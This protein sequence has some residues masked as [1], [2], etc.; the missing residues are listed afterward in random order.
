MSL[1]FRNLD[2]SAKKKKKSFSS[3]HQASTAPPP[4]MPSIL[5]VDDVESIR[6]MTKRLLVSAGCT[7]I[8]TAV[9]GEDA[10]IKYANSL[11]TSNQ[12]D[13]IFMDYTMPKM[14]G[15]DATRCIRELGFEGLVIGITGNAMDADVEVFKMKGATK[16]IAKPFDVKKLQSILEGKFTS[17][18]S[19]VRLFSIIKSHEFLWFGFLF[20]RLAQ[21]FILISASFLYIVLV[22][23]YAL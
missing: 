4:P 10:V 6:K 1:W 23:C 16:V 2:F 12:F 11:N 20:Y 22:V 21:Y 5:V 19:F 13:I 9:D 3:H 7:H 14:N 17:I 8:E 15:G 18:H